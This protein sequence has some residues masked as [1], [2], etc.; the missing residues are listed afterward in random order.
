MALCDGR[1]GHTVLGLEDDLAL[2][3]AV[4]EARLLEEVEGG[5][6]LGA[7]QLELGV[8]RAADHAR[9]RE[10]ADQGDD[11]GHEHASAASV[12]GGASR[13]SMVGGPHVRAVREHPG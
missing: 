11:P 13:S 5:L 12:H 8:E 6:A 3:L 2:D 1:I 7:G 4:A 9:E 10:G